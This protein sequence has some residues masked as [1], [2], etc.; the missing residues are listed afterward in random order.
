[1]IDKRV[2]TM[3]AALAG[4]QDGAS[5]MLSGFGGAGFPVA[6][7]RG[8]E[9]TGVRELTLIMNTLRLA[10]TW[11][12]ALF[13]ERRV[14]RAVCS[15]ARARD[16]ELTSFEKQYL[17]GELAVEIV[18]QGTFSER[19]RAGGAGIPAFYTPAG[20]GTRL[21]EGKEVREF[22]GRPYLLETA[23]TA[24]F[25]LLRAH[26]ADR[27]GNVVFRGSQANFGPGMAAA[28][29]VTVVEVEEISE[30]PLDPHR[31][32]IPGVYVQRVIRLPDGRR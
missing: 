31:I 26:A 4:L 29:R 15:A 9:A 12:P 30:A 20:Y 1:M 28:A 19:V 18:P 25:A 7:L 2:T 8:V 13:D 32:D 21:A 14:R 16:E 6:L 22:D 10:Q 24:D 5:L 17:A 3:Q 11:A 27:W 23:L